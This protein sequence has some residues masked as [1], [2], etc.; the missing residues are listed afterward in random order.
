MLCQLRVIKGVTARSEPGKAS[1]WIREDSDRMPDFGRGLMS[2]ALLSPM[3]FALVSLIDPLG[4]AEPRHHSQALLGRILAKSGE[5]TFN[6]LSQGTAFTSAT[7][8]RSK[9]GMAEHD[10]WTAVARKGSTHWAC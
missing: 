2:T 3:A 4:R 1:C 7:P 10:A 8:D 6:G 5:V 9:K